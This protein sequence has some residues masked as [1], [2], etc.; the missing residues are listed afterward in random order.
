[1]FAGEL[2]K[3]KAVF[4][5]ADSVALLAA[6]SGS[7]Y[8][9]DPS[10]AMEARIVQANR[11][12][13]FASVLA[14]TALWILVFHACDLYRM[15]NGGLKEAF[16]V[17]KACSIAA[18]L[19]LL[20]GFLAHLEVS[21]LTVILA[22]LFSTP[23]VLFIRAGSRVCIRRLYASPKIA[24]PLLVVGFNPMAHYLFDQVLDEMTPYEP[25][26]FLDDCATGRQYRGYP[27][28]GT[29]GRLD[30]VAGL[31]PSLEVAVAMPDAPYEQQE[32][33]VRLCESSRV[34]WW[35]VPWIIRSLGGGLKVDTLGTIP[36]LGPRCSNIEGLNFAL[37]RAFDMVTAS[38]A[39]MLAA[40]AIAFGALAIWLTDGRPVFF[41][42]MRIGIHGKPF[43]LLK[44]RTMEASA[45]DK[46]HRAY[47][48]RWIRD[49]T[50]AEQKKQGADSK[51][52]L[53]NDM[54]ITRVGR[55]LRRFSIDELPQLIN[56]VRGEMS[57]IG[58]RPALPYELD[59]YEE[60]HRR[61]LDALP[62][63]T[64]L[65]QVSGRNN[66]SFGDMV[67]LDVQYLEDWSFT[68]DLRILARTFPALLRGEGL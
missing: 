10:G 15:R 35:V 6:F 57:L 18:L 53:V 22:Y 56:V 65:W 68:G 66:L 47:V 52:K 29:T 16:G 58:P 45:D 24:I 50:F 27:V 34:R 20:G 3:Q 7:L 67:R 60:W 30:R 48:R 63:I 5:A 51:F 44:L 61:R 31:Y 39:L 55:I 4:A 26:G 41:R 21:R 36:L 1:M 11:P 38:I 25:V 13:L 32:R 17:A 14:V 28:I 23:M 64:G 9:H 33:I 8:L 46:V 62:G 2:Q 19:T 37:K 54:R 43:Q 12:L 59:L 49:G 42:Q 40:P